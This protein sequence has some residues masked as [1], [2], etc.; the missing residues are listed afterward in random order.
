MS[1]LAEKVARAMWDYRTRT[2]CALSIGLLPW[3]QETDA[4]RED[5]RAEARAALR[6]VRDALAEPDDGMICEGEL[7]V[8]EARVWRAMLAASP[9]GRIEE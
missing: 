1:D 4:L 3:N 2:A 5:V 8:S 9:L 7:C 6:V